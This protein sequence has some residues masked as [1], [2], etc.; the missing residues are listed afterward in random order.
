MTM[1]YEIEVR[2]QYGT[3]AGESFQPY[4]ETVEAL[5]AS[6]AISR[7]QRQNPGCLVRCCNSYN[8]PIKSG[9]V[10]DAV[11]WCIL[12]GLVFCIWL[13]VEYWYI[14]IPAFTVILFVY[15]WDKFTD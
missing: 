9:D 12:A 14:V 2:H 8:E 10:G 7:V 6:D 3:G 5:T 11:G 13:L 1:I 4:I 15:L